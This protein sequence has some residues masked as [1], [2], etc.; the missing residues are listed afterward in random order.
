MIN[1]LPKLNYIKRIN[2]NIIINNNNNQPT[3]LCR[4]AITATSAAAIMAS[5]DDLDPVLTVIE[6]MGSNVKKLGQGGMGMAYRLTAHDGSYRVIKAPY[7]LFCIFLCFYL[8]FV[9][10]FF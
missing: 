7:F 5:Q 8:F 4:F 10:F 2:N 1:K 3:D 6:F 9:V